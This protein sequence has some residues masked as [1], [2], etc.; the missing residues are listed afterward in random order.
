LAGLLDGTVCIPAATFSEQTHRSMDRKATL[1]LRGECPVC[2]LP[3]QSG[4]G[5]VVLACRFFA[6]SAVPSA[7]TA[8]ERDQ[9]SPLILG[10]HRCVPS[11]VLTLLAGFQTEVRFA[12]AFVGET[13]SPEHAMTSPEPVGF[14]RR[15]VT[16]LGRALR[17]GILGRSSLEYM[18]QFTASDECCNRAIAAQLGWPLE[19]SV[20]D[21]PRGPREP[22]YE[23]VHGW[24]RR[25]LEDYL[26]RNPSYTLTYE[27]E[28]Q[29]LSPVGLLLVP[30]VAA[31]RAERRRGETDAAPL[32][33]DRRQKEAQ[34][35]WK[36]TVPTA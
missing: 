32:P 26:R 23:P 1:D 33:G 10:H 6:T 18:K 5:V 27:A 22:E 28:L 13:T 17:R 2:T 36:G 29:R 25:Q 30:G 8:G 4:E 7:S 35:L 11:R 21:T 34:P 20:G 19:R 14:L 3:Y 24:T 12:T 16:A 15:S 9:A 31:D